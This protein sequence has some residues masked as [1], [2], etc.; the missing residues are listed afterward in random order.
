MSASRCGHLALLCAWLV[1]A[2]SA[3]PAQGTSTQA[4]YEPY[5][6]Q[7]GK[8]VVWVPTPQSLVD[9]MLDIARLGPDDRLID[10]GS[11][12]GRTV[13]TAA[14]RGARALGIEYD[15]DMVTLAKRNAQKAGVADKARFRRAD[16][17]QAD[18]SAATVITM[19]LLPEINMKL[20]PTLLALK[21]GTRIVSNSFRMG[22]WKPDAT[23][24]AKKDCTDYCTAH[25]WIVPASVAGTWN[26]PQ[27]TLTL[28]QRFQYFTGRLQGSQLAVVANGK[29]NGD[30]ISFTVGHTR[31]E[32]RVAGDT[33]EGTA[34]SKGSTTRWMATRS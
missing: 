28:K 21:P 34:N 20:R 11:G 7:E 2:S 6:G 29:L 25:L 19:F 30:Y 4:D 27:G 3:V 8:D 32:G 16:L 10:L 14:T 12:D 23:T 15:A 9:R 1:F 18:L 5:V 22:N 33:I 31:Y 26:T 13:I 17:F 24:T